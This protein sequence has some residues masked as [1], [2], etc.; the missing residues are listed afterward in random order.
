M[1]NF[2]DGRRDCAM[3]SCPIYYW[4]PYRKLEPDLSWAAN[5]RAKGQEASISAFA[6]IETEFQA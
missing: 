2:V 1:A 3:P 6:E 4:M 5:T